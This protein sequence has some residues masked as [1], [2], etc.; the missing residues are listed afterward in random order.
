MYR[1]RPSVTVPNRYFPVLSEVL[2]GNLMPQFEVTPSVARSMEFAFT[3]RKYNSNVGQNDSDLMSVTVDGNAGPFKVSS[4][5]SNLSYNTG[6][7]AV[8][9]WDVAG[10]DQSPINTTDVEI[11][12]ST[13]GGLNFTTV[14]VASTPNDGT[15]TIT[16]PTVNPTSQA[17]IMVRANGNVYYAVNSTDFTITSDDFSLSTTQLDQAVCLPGNAVYDFTYRTFNGYNAPTNLTLTG[18]PA[19]S[20]VVITPSTVTNDNTPVNITITGLTSAMVGSYNLSFDGNSSTAMRSTALNLEVLESTLTTVSLTQPMDNA[21][22]V[23]LFPTLEWTAP[24]SQEYDIEI[25]TD[26]NFNLIINTTTIS[27]DSF[28]IMNSLTEDTLYYWRVKNRNIC[29]DGNFSTAR[30]FRTASV[31]CFNEVATAIPVTI[32]NGPPSFIESIITI[33]TDVI[34]NDVSLTIDLSHT[35]MSDV[36]MYLRSPEGTQITIV[37]DRCSNRNDMLATFTDDGSPINCTF[38]SPTIS[39]IVLP[40]DMFSAFNGESSLGDWT[41]TIA[42]DT[43]QDGGVLN[44]WSLDICG[45]QT[46]S[47]EQ[48]FLNGISLYPNPS[49]DVVR[50]QLGDYAFAKAEYQIYD[51]A[52]R[53]IQSQNIDRSI[54]TINVSEWSTGMYLVKIIVDGQSIVKQLIKQ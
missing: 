20:N 9:N 21:V 19:G 32:S 48:E 3:V 13:D 25:A 6:E 36:D 26:S 30:S 42:D 4:Q 37:E 39:G 8:I 5:D 17:R 29:G 10:T 11:L 7:A 15:E 45:T 33:N 41:L 24:G 49:K 2:Q 18:A 38:S 44:N 22:D 51:M 28:T 31:S 16:I 35:W 34:I 47:L 14:I 1:S 27:T 43:T 50:M 52:G 46:L 54:T 40:V 12:L 23:A 53:F